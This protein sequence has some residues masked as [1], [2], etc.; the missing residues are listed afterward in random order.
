MARRGIWLGQ[1]D[2]QGLVEYALIL[3]LT[4]LGMVLAL[5]LL[6]ESLGSPVRGSSNTL[7]A[8][9]AE[10]P[11]AAE[12]GSAAGGPLDP[13][14]PAGAGGSSGK[15]GGNGEGNGGADGT[16]DRRHRER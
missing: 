11:G 3:A 10:A 12:P 7:D 4:S 9:T 15:G 13:G 8:V 14:Q 2:G 5:L 16:W 6:R 1:D